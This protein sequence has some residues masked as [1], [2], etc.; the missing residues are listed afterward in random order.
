MF[1]SLG[2]YRTNINENAIIYVVKLNCDCLSMAKY[3]DLK[4]KNSRLRNV[5][6]GYLFYKS[7][8]NLNA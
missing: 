3:I 5:I 4:L 6:T 2:Q 1:G 8:R 7:F